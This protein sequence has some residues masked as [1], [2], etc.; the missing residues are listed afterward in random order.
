M[1]YSTDVCGMDLEIAL[2][3]I[4]ELDGRTVSGE[5]TDAIFHN[6]CVGK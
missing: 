6:F 3:A 4:G 1:A 5:I 2:S